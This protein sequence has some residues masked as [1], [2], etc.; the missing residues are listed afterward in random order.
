MEHLRGLRI[1]NCL[2]FVSLSLESY[3]CLIWSNV[4]SLP[5][6]GLSSEHKLRTHTCDLQELCTWTDKPTTLSWLCFPWLTPPAVFPLGATPAWRH[7]LRT[8]PPSPVTSAA[9]SPRLP[10]CSPLPLLLLCPTSWLHAVFLISLNNL[11]FPHSSG[12]TPLRSCLPMGKGSCS[13]HGRDRCY[14]WLWCLTWC[15][16]GGIEG[17]QP[18]GWGLLSSQHI[19]EVDTRLAW[20]LA[21]CFCGGKATQIW[22]E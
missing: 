14:H 1:K 12:A 15:H 3:S 10:L 21:P 5:G 22:R 18:R 17:Q 11:C 20:G 4:P 13:E 2:F 6:Q 9:C 7:T 16:L 19:R 8:L